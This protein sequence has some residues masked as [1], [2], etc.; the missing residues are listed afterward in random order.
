MLFIV[1]GY[2]GTDSEALARRM[3][4]REGHLQGVQVLR[5]EGKF[6]Y[7]GALLDSAGNMIGSMMILDFPSET[8][9]RTEFLNEEPYVQ[10]GVWKTVNVHPF[11]LP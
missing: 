1:I 7:G 4:A 5:D 11:R 9:L 3:A 6:Q 8:D 2:D 10:Q